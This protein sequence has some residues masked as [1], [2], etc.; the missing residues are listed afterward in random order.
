MNVVRQIIF[1][2]NGINTDNY[3]SLLLFSPIILWCKMLQIAIGPQI[4]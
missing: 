3:F 4:I 2:K 1:A